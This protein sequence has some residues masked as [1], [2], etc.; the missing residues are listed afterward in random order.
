VAVAA[1]TTIGLAAKKLAPRCR[2]A[3][4]AVQ[5]NAFSSGGSGFLGTPV[6]SSYAAYAVVSAEPPA[7]DYSRRSGVAGMGMKAQ[8]WW[9]NNNGFDHHRGRIF[10]W[11]RRES[12][13]RGEELFRHDVDTFE[14][15]CHNL[16]PAPGSKKRKVVRGRG[17]YGHHGRTCGFGNGGVKKRGR[18]HMN[19]WF[20]GGRIPLA[21]RLPKLTPEQ[22]KTMRRPEYTDVSLQILNKCHDGDEVD[23][24]D[25]LV[26]GFRVRK[27]D[28]PWHRRIKIMATEKMCEEFTVKNLTVYA[29]AFEPPAKEKIEELG[30]R[31]VRIHDKTGFPVEGHY[32]MLK[33]QLGA[34]FGKGAQSA[35][36]EAAAQEAEEAPEAPAEE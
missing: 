31:C 30:G 14:L 11:K 26:R 12:R 8:V 10:D 20:E 29:N 35:G 1:L 17:K 18:R 33:N 5:C 27:I 28:K 22:Q 4:A 9:I 25:L 24:Q 21:R 36:D 7:D 32:Q 23:Y 19:P 2:S 34:D 13:R 3:T 16:I 6:A 15:T